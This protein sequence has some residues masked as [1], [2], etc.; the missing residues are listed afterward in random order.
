MNQIYH[1]EENERKNDVNVVSN[2]RSVRFQFQSKR[3]AIE[4]N[5]A[6]GRS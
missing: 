1:L 4:I 5:R 6:S 3:F 2:D